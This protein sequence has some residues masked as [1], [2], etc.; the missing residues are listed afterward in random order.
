[1]AVKLCVTCDYHKREVVNMGPQGFGQVDL[2]S[3]EDCMHPVNGDPVMCDQA[4]QQV[5]FCGFSGKHWKAK[6][7]A[8]AAPTT[9]NVIQL[10]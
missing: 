1:M 5:V 8:E 7:A 4:R 10:S 6:Q 3:H 2:C 9:D